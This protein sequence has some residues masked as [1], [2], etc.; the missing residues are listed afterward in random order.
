YRVAG[1]VVAWRLPRSALAGL[2][3]AAALPAWVGTVRH[4]ALA[5]SA[6]QPLNGGHKLSPGTI[7]ADGFAGAFALATAAVFLLSAVPGARPRIGGMPAW[8]GVILGAVVVGALITAAAVVL[9]ELTRRHHK[10]G[11]RY[12]IR[13]GKRGALATGRA[14]RGR[15]RALIA[16]A[17]AW[18]GPRW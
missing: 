11:R 5:R 6:A 4:A 12:A 14:A 3:A 10:T 16:R 1:K 9:A 7:L 13:Q 18:A 17:A 2:V 15:W 8:L